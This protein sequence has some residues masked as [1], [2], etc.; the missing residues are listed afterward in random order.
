MVAR[1]E[2]TVSLTCPSSSCVCGPNCRR[3]TFSTF[4][5]TQLGKADYEILQTTYEKF[6]PDDP[7]DQKFLDLLH[8]LHVLEYRNAEIWYDTHPIV[9]DL[10][11]LKDVIDG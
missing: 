10:L 2:P 1:P 4:S 5:Q 6:E 3:S 11:K 8:S 7:K 9:T